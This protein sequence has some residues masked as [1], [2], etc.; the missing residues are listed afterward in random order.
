MNLYTFFNSATNQ[1]ILNGQKALSWTVFRKYDATVIKDDI[2]PP[3]KLLYKT[4]ALG[5]DA[6]SR[7]FN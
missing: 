2:R 6:S 7:A 3:S 4:L 1:F 5:K